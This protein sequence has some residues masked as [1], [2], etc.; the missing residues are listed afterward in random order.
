MGLTNFFRRRRT[1]Q[2]R[3]TCPHDKHDVFVTFEQRRDGTRVDVIRCSGFLFPDE[4]HCDKR[5]LRSIPVT[6]K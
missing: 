6:R 5:C 4:V 3:M 2:V 1:Q